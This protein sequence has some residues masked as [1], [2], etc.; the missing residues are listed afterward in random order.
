MSTTLIKYDRAVRPVPQDSPDIGGYRADKDVG[1]RGRSLREMLSLAGW[2]RL[3]LE[4]LVFVAVIVVVQR[5]FLGDAEIPGLPHPYWLP[6]LLAACQYGVTGGMIA[7]VIASVVYLFGL[8]PQSAA[9]D[10]Y[11]YART[12]AIQPAAWLAT[13]LVFGGLRS[14]HIHQNSELAD[15]FA[16]S[17]RRAS[18]LSDGLER[19]TAEISALE[20]RI[21]VDM[22]SV[23]ALSRSLSQID[24][25][26]RRAAATSLA[27]LFRVGTGTGTF[28]VYLK[29][30][31]RYAPVWAI[32]EDSPR[33][34]NSME[35]LAETAIADMLVESAR[36]GLTDHAGEARFGSGRFVVAVPPSGVGLAAI[37]CELQESQDL[38]QFRR[39]AEEFGRLFATILYA[40]LS[41]PPETRS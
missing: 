2:Q 26:N 41:S 15:N 18:D 37:V 20:R 27:E 36:N 39:R 21:A 16:V 30:E 33:S 10:F 17:R 6:V 11:A 34:T 7:T 24:M 5:R 14:L 38:K 28:T 9:Q 1:R 40:S 19:A 35:S 13:A 8:S 4:T 31:S 29:E 23:A 22:S 25:S 12:V 3:V 32:V